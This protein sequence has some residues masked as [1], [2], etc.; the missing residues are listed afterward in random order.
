VI[1]ECARRFASMKSMKVGSAA[2]AG[3]NRLGWVIPI[4]GAEKKTRSSAILTRF[5]E[6]C[7]GTSAR[8][9]IIPTASQLEA[10][11][12][13]Y[14]KL[15]RQMGAQKLDIIDF[16]TREDCSDPESLALLQQATGIY[17]TG[18]NQARLSTII[19]ET[20][21]AQ[22]IIDSNIA[23]THVAGTSAG[24][25]FISRL[26]IVM[27]RTGSTP[28]A[29][30]VTLSQGLGL[31]DRVIVDQHFRERDRLGRLL[32]ALAHYPDTIGIGVDE[33]TAA[34][35]GPDNVIEIAGSGGVTVVDLSG[36]EHSSL[37]VTRKG[38]AVG[39]AGIKLHILLSGDQYNLVT[40]TA[41]PA[42]NKG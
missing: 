8:I 22:Q 29:G 16:D 23:G 42:T 12:D 20:P 9:V 4:G 18:G 2:V 25:A 33:D 30:M 37:E 10:T 39:L 21:V 34:F 28:K 13:R 14:K 15:F 5:V 32:V 36:L 6:L 26:M 19:G 17:F 11:G 31:S 7:G 38:K 3:N 24:A 1:H 35:I 40:R 41:L 27:G